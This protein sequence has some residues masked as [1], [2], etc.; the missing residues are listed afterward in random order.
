MN[1]SNRHDEDDEVGRRLYA[2]VVSTK[3]GVTADFAL[4]YY[5]PQ[6]VD[7]GWDE[8]GRILQSSF[9]ENALDAIAGMSKKPLN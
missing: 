2:A 5:V 4:E 7:E 6:Q 8:L 1:N 9:A 3:L